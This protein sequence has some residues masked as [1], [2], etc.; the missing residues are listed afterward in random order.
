MIDHLFKAVAKQVD[1]DAT[2]KS[3]LRT[4]LNKQGLKPAEPSSF[5]AD[6][7]ARLNNYEDSELRREI[8]GW[9]NREIYKDFAMAQEFRIAMMR[10]CQAQLEGSESEALDAANIKDWLRGDLRLMSALKGALI[11]Q[12]IARY[13]ARDMFLSLAHWLR[14]TGKNGVAL[15]LDIT[16]YTAGK[17]PQTPDGTLYHGTAAAMDVY[18]VL[19]QFIDATDEM[20][21]C[22]LAVLAP[23][24]FLEDEKRGLARYQALNLRVRDEVRDRRTPNPLSSLVRLSSLEETGNDAR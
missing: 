1:W 11:Y 18:E 8:R 9:L 15:V 19:R 14:L 17:R 20:E 10:L 24:E 23:P 7:L 22:F 6:E 4:L 3:F 21:S 5:K 12:K 2:T 16:R 13:N